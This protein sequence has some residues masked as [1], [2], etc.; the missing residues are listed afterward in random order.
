MILLGMLRCS[1]RWLNDGEILPLATNRK[2]FVNTW[3]DVSITIRLVPTCFKDMFPTKNIY[4]GMA[5]TV[6]Q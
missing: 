3:I 2:S 4:F 5:G 6:R 1:C